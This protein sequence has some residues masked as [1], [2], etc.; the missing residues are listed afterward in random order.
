MSRGSTVRPARVAAF[1]PQR[2]GAKRRGLISERTL[3]GYVSDLQGLLR[4]LAFDGVT[5]LKEV[6]QDAY[7][8]GTRQA[9]T[10]VRAYQ[11]AGLQ[12]FAARGPLHETVLVGH[13]HVKGGLVTRI[14]GFNGPQ[15]MRWAEKARGE[16]EKAGLLAPDA[17]VT[18]STA[19]RDCRDAR[20]A[21]LSR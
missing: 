9:M 8:Y 2:R 3:T 6:G 17:V 4:K 10:R 1:F 12:P 5:F 18:P 19:L 20:N 21:T 14:E 16:V 11:S 7:G 15:G 13:V